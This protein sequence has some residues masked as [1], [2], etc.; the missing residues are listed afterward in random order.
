MKNIKAY[1]FV[2][3]LAITKSALGDLGIDLCSQDKAI[4]ED[5]CKGY[6]I[7]AID[8]ARYSAR[9]CPD[10]NTSYG[11]IIGSWKI[12]FNR[13]LISRES[14]QDGI[15]KTIEIMGLSCKK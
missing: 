12:N 6:L 4:D 1:I 15:N 14:T 5:F 2:S 8:S 3:L 7:G 11:D 13:G 10:V 9:Y